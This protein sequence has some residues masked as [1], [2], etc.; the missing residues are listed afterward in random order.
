MAGPYDLSGVMLDL[1][2]G[3]ESYPPPYY[4]PYSH[5]GFDQVYDV[6]TNWLVFLASP[7]G[8]QIPPLLDKSCSASESMLSFR[9]FSVTC[10]PLI[11]WL[12]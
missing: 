8:T 9:M 2:P 1:I 3:G 11:W 5:E 6:I 10:C 12:I 4:V 7:Y